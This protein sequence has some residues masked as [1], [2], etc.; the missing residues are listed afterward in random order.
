MHATL[1]VSFIAILLAYLARYQN[2]RYGLE[3]AFVLLTVFIGIRYNWGNDYHSYYQLYLTIT[4]SPSESLSSFRSEVGW[5]FINR[6]STTIGFFG[7]VILLTVFEYVVI[8]YMIKKHVRKEWYWLSVFIFTLSVAFM[9]VT[10]SMMRQF[11]AV[12]VFMI[13]FE[14]LLNRKW[15]VSILL[16]LLSSLFHRSA[17]ILL[18][19]AGIA[20]LNINLSRKGAGVWFLMY[21]VMY[22]FAVDLLGNLFFKLIELEQFEKY[23]TY[24][25]RDKGSIGSGLG[26]LFAMIMYFF[27]LDNQKHQNVKMK[28]IFLMLAFAP[29]FEMFGDISP[30]TSRLAYY[31]SIFSIIVYPAMFG[32]IK[33]RMLRYGLLAGYILITLKSFFE[34]FNPIGIWHEFFYKYQT[35]FSASHWM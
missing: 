7:M 16:I 21:L 14:L 35:I 8:Y 10:S 11:L 15:I 9:L 13:A 33:N 12:C 34:F 20:V 30:Y 26:V 32:T 4:N 31:F 6:I 22:F 28:R 25:F 24:L 5:N 17:L 1:I 27:L 3:T 2:F 18:P 29:L 19:F 23:Q